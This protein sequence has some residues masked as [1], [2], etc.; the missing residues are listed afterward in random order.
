MVGMRQIVISVTVV[1]Y[2]LRLYSVIALN[3]LYAARV[4]RAMRAAIGKAN[5]IKDFVTM[6]II[7]LPQL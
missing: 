7:L 5:C 2:K 6:F 4:M 3:K 1:K